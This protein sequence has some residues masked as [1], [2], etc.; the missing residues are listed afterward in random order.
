MTYN[1]GLFGLN[2][3]LAGLTFK[4]FLQLEC[5]LHLSL[6][7]GDLSVNKNDNCLGQTPNFFRVVFF[8]DIIF[9][10]FS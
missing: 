2:L 3:Y 9:P 6:Q 1:S 10:D 8:K 4:F 5:F 7:K